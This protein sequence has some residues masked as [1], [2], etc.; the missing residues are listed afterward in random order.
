MTGS[1]RMGFGIEY[2]ESRPFTCRTKAAVRDAMGTT[3]AGALAIERR[4]TS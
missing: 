3:C 2:D 4:R 1:H